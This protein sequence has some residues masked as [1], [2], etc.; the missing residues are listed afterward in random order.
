MLLP[1]VAVML[2]RAFLLSPLLS[3]PPVCNS[4]LQTDEEEEEEEA[5]TKKTASVQNSNVLIC[6][7]H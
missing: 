3:T 2:W 1:A 6:A 4:L 5:V 7:L